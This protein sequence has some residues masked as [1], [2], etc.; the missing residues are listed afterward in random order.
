MLPEGAH[1][2]EDDIS[3]IF[4]NRRDR[5]LSENIVSSASAKAMATLTD[6]ED[7]GKD[8]SFLYG[9]NVVRTKY[10]KSARRGA[11]MKALAAFSPYNFID[12]V[13]TILDLAL[14]LCLDLP[15][16]SAGEKLPIILERLYENINK[17]DVASMP[18]PNRLELSLMRRGLVYT[19]MGRKAENHTPAA[20]TH[21][22]YVADPKY[23]LEEP[24]EQEGPERSSRHTIALYVPLQRTPDEFGDVSVTTLVRTLKESTMVVFNAIVSLKRVIFIGYDHSARE[25]GQMVMSSI[26][27]VAPPLQGTIKRAFPYASLTDLSF[28][29]VCYDFIS[30]SFFLL[31]LTH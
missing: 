20:W 26:A 30:A 12:I 25:I 6:E 22:L 2:R 3:Y 24:Q 18:R 31:L 27:M 14:A 8:E 28:E 5:I 1:K 21:K 9:V 13:Q 16:D 29:E 19:P 15:E 4:L 10:D 11:I 23:I 17:C 7:L